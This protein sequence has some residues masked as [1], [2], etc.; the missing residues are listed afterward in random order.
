MLRPS[1]IDLYSI[2]LKLILF[3]AIDEQKQRDTVVQ[4]YIIQP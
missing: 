1:Q 3:Y 4:F 2:I